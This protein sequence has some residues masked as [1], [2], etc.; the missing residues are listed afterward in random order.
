VNCL[1]CHSN[2]LQQQDMNNH[3]HIFLSRWQ[4]IDKSAASCVSCH[5]SHATNGEAQL[6]FLNR[7]TT[8][9][10]CQA[11]HSVLAN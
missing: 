2:I 7:T 8:T 4:A 6:G 10:L 5:Q 9:N 1:K 11:C 3:F